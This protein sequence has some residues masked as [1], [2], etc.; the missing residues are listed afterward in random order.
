[1]L[2][3]LILQIKKSLGLYSRSWYPFSFTYIW[4]FI[5]FPL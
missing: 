4:V 2:F 1:M 5:W 3:I